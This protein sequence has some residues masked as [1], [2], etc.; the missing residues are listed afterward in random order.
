MNS[1]IKHQEIIDRLDRIIN[2]LELKKSTDYTKV[3]LTASEYIVDPL[4]DN[5]LC[6]CVEKGRTSAVEVCPIHG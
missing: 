6:R 2:L 3:E 1:H 5:T 4:I